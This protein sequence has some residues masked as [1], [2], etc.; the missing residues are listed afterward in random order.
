MPVSLVGGLQ[1]QEQ[2]THSFEIS[3]NHLE[4]VKVCHTRRDLRELKVVDE[5]E[6]QSRG[7]G[8]GLTNRK[9]FASGLDVA[10]LITFPLGIH[11]EKI[12]K[13]CG[14]VD[15]ETPNKGK[16]FG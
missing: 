12:R 13:Q 11:S 8:S 9:R 14:S 16:M 7:N 6:R 10:Y 2:R 4:L 5:Q 3:V 15:T 1:D